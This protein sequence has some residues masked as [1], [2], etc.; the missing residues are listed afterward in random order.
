EVVRVETAAQMDEALRALAPEAD[1]V[2]MAAA[3]ADFRPAVVAQD[4]LHRSEG[5]MRLE[6]EPTPDILAGLAQ[7]RRP[8]QLLVGFAAETDEVALRAAEKLRSKG[9]DLVVANDV[10]A[11]GAGFEG[12]TNAVVVIGPE[13]VIAEVPLASKAEVA[14]AVLDVVARRLAG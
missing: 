11:E 14:A 3:V 8:G 5:A 4:K 9:V 6:L 10:R 7:R 12:D 1:V 13:G 2:V